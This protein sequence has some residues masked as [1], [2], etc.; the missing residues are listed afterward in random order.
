MVKE[1]FYL[2]KANPDTLYD[3]I[4][5]IDHA[6][7]KPWTITRRC[8]AGRV[9]SGSSRFAPRATFISSSAASNTCSVS[10]HLLMPMRKGQPAPDLSI[11][12]KTSEPAGPNERACNDDGRRSG[13]RRR[14]PQKSCILIYNH[15]Q[16]VL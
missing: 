11:S 1:R 7:T 8:G 6:L 10:E 16:V 5:T 2:D 14:I 3:E 4:T 13:D 15:L 9:R 12:T